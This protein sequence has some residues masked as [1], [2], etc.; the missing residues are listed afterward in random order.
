MPS[1]RG[2][3]DPGMEPASGMPPVLQ[4]DSLPLA[5]PGGSQPVLVEHLWLSGCLQDPVWNR[6]GQRVTARASPPHGREI[7][8]SNFLHFQDFESKKTH[9]SVTKISFRINHVVETSLERDRCICEKCPLAG[10]QFVGVDS[11]YRAW[12]GKATCAQH[13]WCGNV[14]IEFGFC[15]DNSICRA[16]H[17]SP[18]L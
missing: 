13:Y 18:G 8:V 15:M 7:K 4:A 5:P 3:P 6:T 11:L 16:M 17:L 2:S 12:E 1:S 14:H 10:E 9:F